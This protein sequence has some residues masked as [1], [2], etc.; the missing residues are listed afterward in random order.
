MMFAVLG[1]QITNEAVLAALHIV[2][3][4]L[5]P[6]GLFV[7]DVWNGAAVLSTRPSD[8]IKIIPT[9]GGKVIRAPSGTLDVY[10]HTADVR[11]QTWSIKGQHI[12]SETEEIHRMR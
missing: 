8:R 1:Y 4:H 12:V 3:R 6:W 2:R 5:R 9:S 10:H 7:C 11:Y